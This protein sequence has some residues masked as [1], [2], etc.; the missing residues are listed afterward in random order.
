MLDGLK[1]KSVCDDDHEDVRRGS[2]KGESDKSVLLSCEIFLRAARR[3]RCVGDE[4]TKAKSLHR[5][6]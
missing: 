5:K 6:K 2:G 1:H 4:E 3:A